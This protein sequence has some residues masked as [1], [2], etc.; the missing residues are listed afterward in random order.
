MTKNLYPL[1]FEPMLQYRIWGGTRLTKLFEVPQPND[2][3]IGEAWVLSDRDDYLSIVANG[4]LKGQS[5]HQVITRYHQEIFGKLAEHFTRFPLLLK[6]LDAKKMLSVQVHPSDKQKEYLPP[7]QHG[8]TEG[9]VVLEAGKESRI[10]AGLKPGTNAVS[11]QSA[12]EKNTIAYSLLGFIPKPGDAV[13]IPAGTVHSMGND[14]MVFEVQQNSDV[15]FRLFDWNH[16]DT[17]TRKPRAL[18][19]PQAMACINFEKQNAGKVI[20]LPEFVKPVLKELLFNCEQFEVW[21]LSG[22]K[23]FTVGT[24]DQPRV[25]VCIEGNGELEHNNIFYALAKGEVFLLPAIIGI[26]NFKPNSNICLLEIAI[27]DL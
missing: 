21:R 12:I 5:I 16:I 1:K 25:L 24:D 11:L 4:I 8:K 6:F 10:Y 9:W 3:P 23:E 22:E 17:K 20:P 15:T 14:V 7:T 18:Q 13:F 26:C 2:E 27:P 19:I